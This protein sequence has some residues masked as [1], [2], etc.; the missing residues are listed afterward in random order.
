VITDSISVC[1]AWYLTHSDYFIVANEETAEV[2]RRAGV[3]P[4]ALRVLGFPV[5]PLFA[6]NPA[7]TKDPRCVSARPKLLYVINTGKAH[8]GNMLDQLLELSHLEVTLTTGRNEALRA[9]LTHRLRDHGHRVR[10]LGWTDQMPQLLMSHDLLIAKA[11]G[12]T[13]QEAIAACCPM[14]INQVIPGQEEGNA[15]LIES[16]GAGAVVSKRHSVGEL[17]QHAFAENGRLWRQWRENLARVTRPDSALRIAD[18]VLERYASSVSPV[19]PVLTTET[20]L[21]QASA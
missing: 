12:A 9:R 5:S 1:A 19:K 8:T 10:I 20:Q 2:L 3:K 15:K 4:N 16:L 17:V 11:G 7:A 14:I 13:V 18:L 21:A 6:R